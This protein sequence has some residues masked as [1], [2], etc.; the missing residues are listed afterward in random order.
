MRPHKPII[1]TTKNGEAVEFT[2]RYESPAW[3]NVIAGIK[4][5][6]WAALF[7]S[8]WLVGTCWIVVKQ[9]FDLTQGQAAVVAIGWTAG[10]WV[11]ADAIVNM[12]AQFRFGLLPGGDRRLL[13]LL[14]RETVCVKSGKAKGIYARGP[15]LRFTAQPH[16]HGKFEA[17]HAE[18]TNQLGPHLHRDA[19]QVWLQHGNRVIELAA[20][21]SEDEANAIV[22]HLQAADEQASRG[23][24]DT[25]I[26][27]NRPQ[28]E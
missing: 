28:P 19:F 24:A 13:L 16:V 9:L 20:A 2:A 8:L 12:L 21:S 11:I 14:A 3:A 7:L 22:R 25:D 10:A 18:R 6:L 17:R 23:S 26:F 4:H 1:T 5:V 27:A 15:A